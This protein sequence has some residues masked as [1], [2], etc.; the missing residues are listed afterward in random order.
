[1]KFYKAIAIL[2]FG[3]T[4]WCLTQYFNDAIEPKSSVESFDLY[5][6]NESVSADTIRISNFLSAP[7]LTIN[8]VQT[9]VFTH[10]VKTPQSLSLKHPIE[11][12]CVELF[13]FKQYYTHWLNLPIK[14]RKSD[15][16]FPFHYFW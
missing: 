3:F 10:I 14:F 1:M 11:I 6:E 7:T 13:Y 8:V 2:F 4:F 15:L 16:I 9:T 5:G 12:A